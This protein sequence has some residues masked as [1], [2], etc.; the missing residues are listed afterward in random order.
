M[1][2]KAYPA[3]LALKAANI[4]AWRA[5][6]MCLHNQYAPSELEA[7][8]GMSMR[9]AADALC[10]LGW[11]RVKVWSRDAYR[12]RLRTYWVPPGKIFHRPTRGRPRVNLSAIFNAI[13][14][15]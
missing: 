8:L 2:I 6:Q 4:A 15:V 9:S 7:L 5:R 13:E 10:L 12:R 14:R 3:Q 1:F 11:K